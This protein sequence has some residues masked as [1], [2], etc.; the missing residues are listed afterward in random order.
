MNCYLIAIWQ[1]PATRSKRWDINRSGYNLSLNFV[2]SNRIYFVAA[3]AWKIAR[4]GCRRCP[5]EKKF[6]CQSAA[7]VLQKQPIAF[8]NLASVRSQKTSG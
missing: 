5:R 2:P 8:L 7:T 3:E 4:A 1:K 6:R